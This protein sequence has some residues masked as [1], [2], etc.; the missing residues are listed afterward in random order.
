MRSIHRSAAAAVLA[1]LLAGCGTSTS[2]PPT[3]AGDPT[4]APDFQLLTDIPIPA[5]A[6]MDNERSLILGLR[7]R[8]TGRLV[9]KVWKSGPETT[10]FFQQQM[11][12]FGWEPVMAV[13]SG[14]SVLSYTRGDRAATVQVENGA[15]WGA[16]VA[17]TVAPR[18]ASGTGT[19]TAIMGG[20]EPALRA[21]PA[22]RR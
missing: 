5:G 20:P 16:T 15:V 6:T 12:A 9:M 17:V 21:V 7:D 1:L 3:Q 8:W 10:A 18:H 13:T 14:I 11:P 2:L 22:S 4:Q 19:G